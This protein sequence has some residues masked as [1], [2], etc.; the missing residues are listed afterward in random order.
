M[1]LSAGMAGA[2]SLLL[3]RTLLG[4]RKVLSQ[5]GDLSI[6]SSL[7]WSLWIDWASEDLRLLVDDCCGVFWATTAW[8]TCGLSSGYDY[9]SRA[10]GAPISPACPDFV[11]GWTWTQDHLGLVWDVCILLS[12]TLASQT[13]PKRRKRGWRPRRSF[14]R[15]HGHKWNRYHIWRKMRRQGNLTWKWQKNSG[16]RWWTMNAYATWSCVLR[17]RFDGFLEL[18]TATF[19]TTASMTSIIIVTG[20]EI[21]LELETIDPSFPFVLALV[22]LAWLFISVCVVDV[23]V[24]TSYF[25]DFHGLAFDAK[26]NVLIGVASAAFVLVTGILVCQLWKWCKRN[27]FYKS[28]KTTGQRRMQPSRRLE[29]AQMIMQLLLVVLC[30][31]LGCPCHG[32]WHPSLCSFELLGP[33]RRFLALH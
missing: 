13:Q 8:S 15:R 31:W 10:S 2:K 30:V 7:C 16:T 28:Q 23:V 29:R 21:V 27:V 6:D 5:L 18:H 33:W 19:V 32:L 24:N 9:G 12:A 4:S 14:K 20:S 25:H 11:Q 1:K 3:F 22:C 17:A 26:D